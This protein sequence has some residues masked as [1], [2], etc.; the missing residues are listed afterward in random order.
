MRD[1]DIGYR[2]AESGGSDVAGVAAVLGLDFSG[3]GVWV[4]A[5]VVA[6]SALVRRAGSA[7]GVGDRCRVRAEVCRFLWRKYAV[8]PFDHTHI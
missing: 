8:W 3:A 6:V 4:A 7:I 5:R 2:R 1:L